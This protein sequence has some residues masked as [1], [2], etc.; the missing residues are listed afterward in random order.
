MPSSDAIAC[1][2]A[3]GLP[4]RAARDRTDMGSSVVVRCRSAS[5]RVG[6]A[7]GDPCAPRYRFARIHFRPS[8]SSSKD[9]ELLAPGQHPPRARGG[10]RP[11]ATSWTRTIAAPCSAATPS[12]RERRRQPLGGRSAGDRAERRTCARSPARTGRPS[13]SRSA[14]QRPQD[15]DRLRG[16]SWRSPGPGRRRAARRP[17]RG[18][19]PR[20]SARAGRRS[21]SPTTSPP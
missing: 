12:G 19:A 13:S 3:S 14:A 21:T 7:A 18:R 20:R 8:S 9:A 1:R 16:A 6:T 10:R 5:G 4:S 15:R 17:R 2:S 11:R